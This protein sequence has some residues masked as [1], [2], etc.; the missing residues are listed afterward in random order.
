MNLPLAP[1]RTFKVGLC[2]TIHPNYL[3]DFDPQPLGPSEFLFAR[4]GLEF[5]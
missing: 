3:N 2:V 4:A 5:V 1:P